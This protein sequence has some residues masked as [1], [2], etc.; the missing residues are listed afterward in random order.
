MR[1]FS[2]LLGVNQ[3]MKVIWFSLTLLILLA[4]QGCSQTDRSNSV[5][6]SSSATETQSV[7]AP[8]VNTTPARE[9]LKA[10]ALVTQAEMSRILG[11]DVV[12]QAND[13]SNGKTECIYKAASG[14]SPYVEF[15]VERGEGEM[16]LKA[17]GAMGKVEPGI[18]NPYEGIGDEAAAVGPTLWI[19]TGDDLVTIVFSGVKDAPAKAK[20]I[21][22]TAKVRM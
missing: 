8:A 2:L 10:C 9:S 1:I 7:A 19:R 18:S 11:A 17:M 12:A 5:A 14:I 20:Q 3:A 22:N 16:A 21:F 13:H 15:T 4:L 6:G